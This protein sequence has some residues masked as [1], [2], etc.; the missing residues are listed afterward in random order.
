[1]S[2]S[3]ERAAIEGRLS[4]NWNTTPICWDNIDY[5]PTTGVSFVRCT[6]L[7]GG[8]DQASLGSNPLFRH[9]GI[10]ALELFV[11][12]GEGTAIAKGHLDSLCAIYRRQEFGGIRCLTPNAIRIGESGGWLK[13]IV[14][15]PFQRDE[16]F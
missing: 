5:I 6:I 16:T 14:N 1:M 8:A 15:I 10:I 4:A 12:V 11:P 7:T 2:Y 13:H 9:Y 3:S